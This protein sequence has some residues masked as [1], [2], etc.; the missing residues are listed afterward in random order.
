MEMDWT[1]ILKRKTDSIVRMEFEW[2]SQGSSRIHDRPKITLWN[3]V[4]GW[5]LGKWRKA[6][7]NLARNRIHWCSFIKALCT[8]PHKTNVYTLF[9]TLF[10]F[11]LILLWPLGPCPDHEL[12][13]RLNPPNNIFMCKMGGSTCNLTCN[14]MVSRHA[15]Y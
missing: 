8:Y 10:F 5:K 12:Y 9:Q 14:L 11:L 3:V 15:D 6:G 4:M 2:N 1:L 7:E 13:T